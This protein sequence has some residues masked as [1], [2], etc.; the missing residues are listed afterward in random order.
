MSTEVISADAI[1]YLGWDFLSFKYHTFLQRS[2]CIG[3]FTLFAVGHNF[4][5]VMMV[6]PRLIIDFKDT[7]LR[8]LNWEELLY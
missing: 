3:I 8:V 6:E 2:C 5:L 4:K 7:Q 1:V